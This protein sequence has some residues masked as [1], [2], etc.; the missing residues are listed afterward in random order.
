MREALLA[1][2]HVPDSL[3]IS[4]GRGPGVGISLANT[5]HPLLRAAMDAGVAAGLQVNPDYNSGH[6]SGI[7]PLQVTSVNGRRVSAADAFIKPIA[8]RP[9]LRVLTSMRVRRVM[10]QGRRAAGVPL[11]GDQGTV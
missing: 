5:D 1:A 10:W 3:G 11:H 8:G 9:N 2:E 4:R 7:G 6:Q